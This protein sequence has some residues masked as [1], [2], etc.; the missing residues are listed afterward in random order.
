MLY[1]EQDMRKMGGLKIMTHIYT[2]L[3]S[4][5]AISGIPPFLDFLERRNLDGSI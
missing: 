4:S 3:I 1:G 5:L 2:F